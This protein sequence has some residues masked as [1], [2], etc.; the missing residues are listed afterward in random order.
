MLFY[1]I[2]T[3]SFLLHFA[4]TLFLCTMYEDVKIYKKAVKVRISDN[5]CVSVWIFSRV[6]FYP[7]L[8]Y[9][10]VHTDF[11]AKLLELKLRSVNRSQCKKHEG[12]YLWELLKDCK[13]GVCLLLSTHV[14]YKKQDKWIQVVTIIGLCRCLCSYS[15]LTTKGISC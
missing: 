9:T 15:A 11:N 14:Q 6:A 10:S 3:P 1:V 13:C 4:I 5:Y 12:V 2:H 8:S 7:H